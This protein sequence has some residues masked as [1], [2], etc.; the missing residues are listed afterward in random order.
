ME[1]V[2]ES[3]GISKDQKSRNSGT[4]HWAVYMGVVYV[5]VPGGVWGGGGAVLS[6]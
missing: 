2:M 3:H 6:C 4:E 1:K 5:C